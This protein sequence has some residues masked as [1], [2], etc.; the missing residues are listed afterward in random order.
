VEFGGG[1]L[2]H[3]DSDID[4]ASMICGQINIAVAAC[5]MQMQVPAS[6][7]ISILAKGAEGG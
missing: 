3:D 4:D 6:V 1:M 2:C 7:G 5:D